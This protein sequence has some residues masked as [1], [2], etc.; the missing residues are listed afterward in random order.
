MK[1][2]RIK[3]LQLIATCIAVLTPLS[4]ISAQGQ[5]ATIEGIWKNNKKGTIISIY[6]DGE[7]YY[8]EVIGSDKEKEDQKIKSHDNKIMI[9]NEFQQ[10]DGQNYCCGTLFIPKKEK[11]IPANLELASEDALL[12]HLSMGSI[13][14]SVEWT[15][16]DEIIAEGGVSGT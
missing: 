15:R 12:I 8:G 10:K 11:H 13:N 7:F 9:L 3:N 2:D 4:F 5:T 16:M 1:I 14:R 6:Q